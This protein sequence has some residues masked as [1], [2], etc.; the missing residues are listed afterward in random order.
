MEVHREGLGAQLPLQEVDGKGLDLAKVIVVP[1]VVSVAPAAYIHH[2]L[3]RNDF[4]SVGRIATPS[5]NM[6]NRELAAFVELGGSH[7]LEWHVVSPGFWMLKRLSQRERITLLIESWEPV[8][9]RAFMDAIADIKSQITLR[10]LIERLERRD[11]VGAI[12]VLNIEREAF[13]PL[14]SAIAQ[15]YEGGGVAMAEDL[16]LRDPEGN[17]IVFR[18]GVRNPEAEAWLRTH[19]ARLVSRIVDDQREAIRAALTE[20]LARGE[21]PRRTALDVVG[22]QSRITGRRVGGIIG[23]TSQQDRYVSAARAE[24]ESGDPEQMNHYLTR[25]R[26]DRRFDAA[27]KRA[28]AAGKPVGAETVVR[29]TGRYS[30]RLLELRGRTLAQNET[31][32]AI[33][34]ARNEGFRQAIAA[35]K[36]D[37]RF[38]LKTWRHFT[39]EHPR[40]QH[41]AMRG[42]EVRFDEPFVMADGTRMAFPHDPAA[43]AR[44]NLGC[45]C[46]VDY[47]IDYTAQFLAR[48][49]A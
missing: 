32:A 49:A 12:A 16:S 17:R 39:A 20:G 37:A 13:G 11:I 29:A 22:R 28:I 41:V 40:M 1:L 10:L 45:K 34:S 2:D 44:H 46:Q 7:A 14:E 24:L 42:K 21:N 35:G 38:V 18:F 43:P 15:A 5:R 36:V 19:S 31:F 9:R 25:Q 30:D 48:R 4:V 23:I 47:T 27:V 3:G 8:V 33:G 6:T 26:R